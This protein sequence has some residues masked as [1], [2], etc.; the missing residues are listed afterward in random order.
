V[1]GKG[2][3]LGVRL[4]RVSQ[5]TGRA[6]KEAAAMPRGQRL[7]LVAFNG[8]FRASDVRRP[9]GRPAGTLAVVVL[10][11]PD[12]RLMGTFIL[13]RLPLAFGHSHL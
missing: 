2:S 8:S 6:S 1:N 12:N 13:R 5:L 3:L 7:C 11:Y 10:T 9:R 4:R